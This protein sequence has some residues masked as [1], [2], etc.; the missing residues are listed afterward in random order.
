MSC[1]EFF[2]CYKSSEFLKFELD[3]I[4]LSFFLIIEIN[5]TEAN[6]YKLFFFLSLYDFWGFIQKFQYYII[7]LKVNYILKSI[8]KLNLV[9]FN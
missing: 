7:F 9:V 2:R 6:K 3:P 8:F 5:K 4:M 1:S